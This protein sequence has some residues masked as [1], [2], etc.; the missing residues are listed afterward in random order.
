[1]EKYFSYIYVQ[2]FCPALMDLREHYPQNYASVL[3]QPSIPR[4][5]ASSTFDFLSSPP[6]Q[7]VKKC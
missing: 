6:N 4:R 1:M 3:S 2:L 5:P 7:K